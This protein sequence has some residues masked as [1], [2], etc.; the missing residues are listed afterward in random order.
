MDPEEAAAVGQ[1]LYLESSIGRPVLKI[2]HLTG[3]KHE[4]GTVNVF[5]ALA[6][7]ADV[8]SHLGDGYLDIA[9]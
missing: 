5:A 3:Q 2:L 7:I 9:A 8:I 6:F 4:T 1:M